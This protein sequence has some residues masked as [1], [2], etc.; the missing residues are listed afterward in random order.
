[1]LPENSTADYAIKLNANKYILNHWKQEEQELIYFQYLLGSAGHLND[2][3]SVSPWQS[4]PFKW[5]VREQDRC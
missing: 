2:I 5:S 4:W 3:F 1:M